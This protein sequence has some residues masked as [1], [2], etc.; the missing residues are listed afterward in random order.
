VRFR[1]GEEGFE[2][3]WVE[4]RA[5]TFEQAAAYALEDEETLRDQA[6]GG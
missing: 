5:M 6:A 2:K 3:A 4:G 1:L